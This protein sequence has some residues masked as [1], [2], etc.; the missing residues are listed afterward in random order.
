MLYRL[1]HVRVSFAGRALLRDVSLQHNPGEKLV[2]LG[3]NGSGKTTLLRVIAGTQE[4]DGG[5]VERASSLAIAH[6]EQLVEPG[7]GTTVLDYCLD[8]FP[9]FRTLE[10][11]MTAGD[12]C[13]QDGDGLSADRLHRLHE[14]FERLDGYRVRPRVEAALDAVGLAPA[15][16]GRPLAS[17]SGGERTRAALVRILLSRAGLLLLDEPTNHLDLLGVEFLAR[18]LAARDGALLLVTHDREL[19]DRVGGQI[20]ELHGGRL[21]RYPAGYARYRREREVRREQARREYELQRAEIARAEEFIRR[22]IAGQNTRQAQSRQ[23]LLDRLEHREPPEVDLPAIAPR[24]PGL[25]RSGQRVLEAEGLA[26]GWGETLLRGVGF[27]LR[28]GERL[29][30]VG[31]NGSGKTTLLQTLCGRL[32]VHGGRLEL[33]SG[34]VLGMYDQD[35]ADVPG[36][37]TI[38]ETLLAA[39]PD[40]APAEARAWA[41]RFG[42]SG[43]RADEPTGTLS[44]GERARLALA[45]LLAAGPNLM[46]LDEPTNHLDLPTCEALEQ[47]LAGFPG[48]VMLVSHDRR[49]LENVATGVLLIEAGAVTLENRVEDAF[50]RLGLSLAR[51][52]VPEAKSRTARRSVIEEER[53]RLRRDVA[54]ARERAEALL[55]EIGGLE[56]RLPEIDELL[57][58]REVYSD[59]ARA[60]ELVAERAAAEASRG[61][62]LDEWAEAEADADALA[63][64][65]A[66]CLE[67]R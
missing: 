61:E 46:L 10:R 31:R 22:N 44:G 35:H 57:C 39:R 53:R 11:A 47:A 41:G 50:A 15:L 32:P 24:W 63:A 27:V 8:A 42:F 55:A 25:S 4:V 64:R 67:E 33:G 28:R 49:L 5:R 52:P 17:L 16:R 1:E 62:L 48:A 3:R 7:D 23:K 2:L 56:A 51:K 13:P 6:L 19:V 12:E 66:E 40:W 58:R 60:R 26:V 36:D 20:L 45:R 21:E 43:A 34:V 38:L 18:E 65:L 14:D 29:A 59:A 30:V 54:R 9:S 37:G